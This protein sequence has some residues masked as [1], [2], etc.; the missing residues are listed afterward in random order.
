M[1]YISDCCGAPAVEGS[2]NTWN[3]YEAG[4][5]LQPN[6]PL[7]DPVIVTYGTCSECKEHI[8]FSEGE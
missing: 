3:D 5:T 7:P 4:A 2:L 1:D 8:L 6:V